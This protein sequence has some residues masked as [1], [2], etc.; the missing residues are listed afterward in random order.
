MDDSIALYFNVIP[1]IAITDDLVYKVLIVCSNKYKVLPIIMPVPC[2]LCSWN[3]PSTDDGD[4]R[5]LQYM[6][7]GPSRL[8]DLHEAEN[9]CA[10]DIGPA[11][12]VSATDARTRRCV[13]HL[14][15]GTQTVE[16]RSWTQFVCKGLR[17]LLELL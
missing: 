1:I 4:P 9:G 5:L 10:Q 15:S 13:L 14:L 2:C 6:V 3:C 8:G 16:Q 7:R 17:Y 11:R 12:G